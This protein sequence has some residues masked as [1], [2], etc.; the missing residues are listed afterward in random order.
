MFVLSTNA[1][2]ERKMKIQ[3]FTLAG[4]KIHNNLPVKSIDVSLYVSS[5]DI[6][7]IFLCFCKEI[8]SYFKLSTQ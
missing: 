3:K 7:Y 4:T 2:K 1:W 6:S 5:D 8:T